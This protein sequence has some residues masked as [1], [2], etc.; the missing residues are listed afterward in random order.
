MTGS[1]PIRAILVDDEPLARQ[2]LR[3]LLA[4]ESAIEVVAE[5]QNGFEAVKAVAEHAPDLVFLDIQMPKLDGFE[6]L[7]LL[8]RPVAVV[9]VTAYDQYALKA[10]DAHAL[11][12]VLKPIDDERFADT[13]QRVREELD[14][15]EAGSQR[16]KLLQLLVEVSGKDSLDLDELLS[17]GRDALE[18]PYL[19]VLP[20]RDAGRTICVKVRDIDWIDAAGD[21]MCVHADGQ[22][23]VMR[24]TMKKLE[25]VLNPR[26]FQRVHRSTIVNVDRVR[27]V[28]SHINGEYFLILDENVE[29]KMSRH[30][31]DRIHHF[32]PAV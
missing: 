2:Y 14:L 12:Y 15:R 3:Q 24:G 29:L 16:E 18:D 17:E 27:E 6:V 28:R 9:F 5:C 11:D 25:S 32:V 23:H 21:Y 4:D 1:D 26:T 22:T 19:D 13:L 20:I 31:K 8:D 7:E 30:Y 10:F